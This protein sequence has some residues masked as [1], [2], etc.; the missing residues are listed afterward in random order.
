[1]AIEWKKNATDHWSPSKESWRLEI[2]DSLSVISVT[3]TPGHKNWEI[4]W[5]DHHLTGFSSKE[6][7]MHTAMK[8]VESYLENT[9]Q[10]IRSLLDKGE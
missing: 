6:F 8:L 2:L 1:M 4:W 9:L 10:E 7:A 3:G 5:I